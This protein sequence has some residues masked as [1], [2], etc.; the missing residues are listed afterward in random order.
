MNAYSGQYIQHHGVKGMRWGVRKEKK[1]SGHQA[2]KPYSPQQRANLKRR[3]N[4]SLAQA[5]IGSLMLT[6]GAT[7]TLVRGRT[8]VGDIARGTG[9]VLLISGLTSA[10]V[11]QGRMRADSMLR[12]SRESE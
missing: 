3:R 8:F 2:S 4:Q 6:A 1:K 7:S 9:G 12:E 5:T 10:V 11:Q